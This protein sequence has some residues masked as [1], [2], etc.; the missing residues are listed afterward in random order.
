MS[1]VV[2]PRP[3]V[4]IWQPDLAH[5][6]PYAILTSLPKNYFKEFFMDMIKY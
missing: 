4:I 5:G 1:G 2:N 3:A 6:L